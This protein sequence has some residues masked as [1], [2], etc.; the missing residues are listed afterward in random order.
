MANRFVTYLKESR[1]EMKRVVWPSRRET[2]KHTILVFAISLAIAAFLG[3]IDYGL[4]RLLQ[5]V[6][7]RR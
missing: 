5:F 4:N 7:N 2:T 1:D 3:I 6:I